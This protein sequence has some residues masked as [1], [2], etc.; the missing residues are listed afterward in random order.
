MTNMI[1]KCSFQIFSKIKSL[2]FYSSGVLEP[3]QAHLVLLP[4]SYDLCSKE[5]E[6]S[7][8]RCFTVIILSG[9]LILLATV[10]ASVGFIL[11]FF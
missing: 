4:S 9:T 10:S 5:E 1:K 8:D 6:E 11:G 3:P 2:D 7:D